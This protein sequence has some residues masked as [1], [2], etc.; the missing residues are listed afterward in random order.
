MYNSI[1]LQDKRTL[2]HNVKG[3]FSG[4]AA[5]EWL[6]FHLKTQ[7]RAKALKVAQQLTDG[8]A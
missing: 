1:K 6:S 8:G 5:V 2:T 7:E 4:K 3:V